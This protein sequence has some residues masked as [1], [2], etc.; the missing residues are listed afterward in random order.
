ME[1]GACLIGPT[2]MESGGEIWVS[3]QIWGHLAIGT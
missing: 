3:N 1:D 2:K